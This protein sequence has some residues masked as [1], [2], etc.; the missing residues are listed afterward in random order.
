MAQNVSGTDILGVSWGS[1]SLYQAIQGNIYAEEVVKG[2][3]SNP[4][5]IFQFDQ[6]RLNLPGDP[7]YCPWLPWVSKLRSHGESIACDT[8]ICV[9]D[10]R[11]TD[12]NSMES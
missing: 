4:N 7:A 11:C 1:Y 9:D 10:V 12:A 5:S 6:V 3:I 2:D 8:L